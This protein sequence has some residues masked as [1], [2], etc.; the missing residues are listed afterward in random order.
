VAPGQRTEGR[1]LPIAIYAGLNATNQLLWLTFA[2]ITTA[3][4]AHFGVSVTS[5]GWLAE[6]F[7]LVYVV[8]AVPAGRLLD[9][10]FRPTLAAGA[11]L[12]ALG[13]LVR[14][15]GHGFA[16]VLA[17]QLVVA[18]AQPFLLNA[19]TRICSDNLPAAERANGIAV[20][21]AG[22]FLGMLGALVLGAV[23]GGGGIEA[24]LAIGAAS[25]TV[26]AL[27]MLAMLRRPAPFE[28]QRS[29]RVTGGNGLRVVWSDR[30]VRHLLGLVFLGFGVFV[31][32]T[33]WLQALLAPAGVSGTD[34]GFLLVMMVVAGIAGSV[35]V[36][37]W[38]GRNSRP[39]TPLTVSLAAT[40]LGCAALAV[41]PG[42]GTG[43]PAA[44]M[45]GFFL[46]ADLPIILELGERRAG[47]AAATVTGLIW[48]AGNAGGL[49]VALGVQA[50]VH[51]PAAG[52]LLMTGAA[53]LA[54]PVLVRFT[55]LQ[56]SL[57]PVRLDTPGA[58]P[59]RESGPH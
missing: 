19:V 32:L 25:A 44:V 36:P 22:I 39:I 30:Y 17:G 16:S 49:V 56:A 9:R 46:V 10:W 45:I 55:R 23:L 14:L 8:G 5:V 58:P 18:V 7:P 2:P 11:A 35:L 31:A 40:A 59:R 41:H 20:G 37:I 15:S 53:L 43:R 42:V 38:A 1:W 29:E 57:V 12:N 4:A 6:I 54:L 13:A 50:L 48:M 3:T 52:F 21:S 28:A 26:A 33:T 34:A 27:A 47:T 51:S 24:L